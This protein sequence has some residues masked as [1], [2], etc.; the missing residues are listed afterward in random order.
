MT[1][2]ILVVLESFTVYFVIVE[3]ALLSD[4]V[5]CPSWVR[6]APLLTSNS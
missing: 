5:V 1:V 4:A 6:I 2:A 3:S